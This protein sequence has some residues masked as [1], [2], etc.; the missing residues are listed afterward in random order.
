MVKFNYIITIHNK[1]E[2]IAKVITG[3]LLCARDGSHVYP[4]LDGCTDRTEEIIDG[5]VENFEGVPVTKVHVND[6]H[7]LLSIN[8]GLRAASHEGEGY[9]IVLQDD[10]ILADFMLE[11]KI[12][13]IYR[14]V[15]PSLG[16]VSLR[17][18]ANFK[19]DAHTSADPV[20]YCDYVENVFGHDLEEAVKIRPGQIAFRTVPI[21][22][23]VCLPFELVRKVGLYNEELAPYGHDD[24]EFALRCISQGYRNAVLPL[25]FYSD[26]TWGGTRKKPH[27]ELNAIV[28]R[29]MNRIRGI[30][31][32]LLRDVCSASQPLEIW[33]VNGIAG[34]SEN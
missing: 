20:P 5:I 30:H 16:Y 17:L 24:P 6:V 7:E 25:R 26:V 21:K 34:S 19:N 10:V 9:N 4:V 22:S 32:A 23:P 2:L 18:G 11:S 1:E 15:G 33:D 3:V 29:N 31:S 14:D 8:A 28:A 12:E 27:P 13:S